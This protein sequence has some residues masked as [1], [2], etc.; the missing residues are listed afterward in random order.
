MVRD[1]KGLAG[2]NII[3]ILMVRAPPLLHY[4]W[5]PYTIFPGIGTAVTK[6]FQLDFATVAI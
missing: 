6:H 3:I 4:M 2:N 5:E 1:D